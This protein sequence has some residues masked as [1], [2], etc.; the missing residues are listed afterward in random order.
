MHA[1]RN[2]WS[3]AAGLITLI[4]VGVGIGACADPCLDDGLGQDRDESCPAID[5]ASQTDS[6]TDATETG[7]DGTCA[8]GIADGDETDVDCGGPTCGA[9]CGDGQDCEQDSD[10]ASNVCGEGNTCE[11]SATCADG[12]VNGDETDV[13]CGGSCPQACDDGE[14]CL[15]DDDCASMFCDPDT[16]TC[17]PSTTCVDGERNGDETDVDC[18]GACPACDDGEGCVVDADCVS[19]ECDPGTMTCLP[20]ASCR[21]GVQ[22]GEESDVDCGGFLCP[23]C[24]D[25]QGCDD[26][27]DCTS[28][29]CDEDAGLCLPPACDDGVANGDETDVDCGGSC[30]TA[31]D[32]GEGC[33]Q[34]LDCLSGI[35]DEDT[36]TC[37]PGACDDGAQN[38]DETDVDC[39]GS[40]PNDCDSGQ[41]CA[42]GDDCISQVC[43][44]DAL[45]C[46]PPAC[47]DGVQN[48]DESDVDCGG[49]CG[50]TCES[51]E[52][53]NSGLDCIDD[54]CDV[55]TNT[56]AP[57]LTVVA[58]PSCSDFEGLPIDLSAVAAGGTGNYTYSWTPAD[59]L[60]DATIANPS[61]LPDSFITYTVTV[62]DGVNTA[63][64]TVTIVDNT[65]FDLETNCVLY[66]GDFLAAA[67]AATITYSQGGTVACELGNN[68]FGLHL[69][70]SVV[71]E[72]VRLQGVIG[73][74]DDANDD[75]II[76]L[77]WGA[78]DNANFY[79]LSWKRAEQIFFGCPIPAGIVVKRVQAP[80]FASLGGDDMYCPNDTADSTTLLLPAETTTAGWEEGQT[81]LVTIDYTAAGSQLTVV[82]QGD[83][84]EI[85]NFAIDD[86]T[87][88]SGAFGSTTLSQANACVGPLN[89]ICL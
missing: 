47:D 61:A 79:S 15:A 38:G 68:D 40:C 26:D 66:A 70:E 34:D 84:V 72:D 80:D 86:A 55:D 24:D 31:C 83:S 37:S 12:V 64:T 60:D 69:C 41:G 85:A 42:D 71:F 21:D 65:A 5:S 62:D 18:G 19:M 4:G 6:D 1:R 28:G 23:S 81:Y 58:A 13:D 16:M 59:T 78:Q 56:C 76:G 9:G 36:N 67:P 77:V 35:C 53:C 44:P 22:N 74:T 50:N 49:A 88:P 33:E 45:T 46:T 63:Q 39:G 7:D 51:G 27:A 2:L 32:D 57:A 8:N 25:G 3:P 87:F 11:P 17:G 54:V 89:A 43:D 82:R 14:G 29:V 20:P 10:C 48:G 52:T 73:V 30:P 75:D